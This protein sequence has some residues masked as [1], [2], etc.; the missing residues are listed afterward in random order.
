[1]DKK[2]KTPKLKKKVY[3]ACPYTKG[4]VARNVGVAIEASIKII[5]LG[6]APVVPVLSHFMEMFHS[7][8]YEQWLELDFT[9]LFDC[10]Y[11]IRLPGE[12]KGAD[13]EVEWASN[14]KIPV[15]LMEEFEQNHLQ[16]KFNE[17]DF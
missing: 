17:E 2:I 8:P 7:L 6:Y 4:S 11:L 12:S 1:M 14:L 13:Q 3:I 9:L 5:K 10:D 16:G 15:F